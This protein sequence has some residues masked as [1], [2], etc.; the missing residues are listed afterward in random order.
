MALTKI[1]LC[2]SYRKRTANYDFSANLYYLIG[3]REVQYRKRA[4]SA[5]R[6][7]RGDTVVEVG[8]GTGL[9]FPHL[10]KA[11]VRLGD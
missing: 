3:I 8:C 2:D 5:L 10:C 6:L 1:Q 4:V 9:I 11:S 7:R